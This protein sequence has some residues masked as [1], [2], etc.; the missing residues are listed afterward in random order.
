MQENKPTTPETPEEIETKRFLEE[1]RRRR[2]QS[3]PAPDPYAEVIA[4][5]KLK[6]KKPQSFL[7]RHHILTQHVQLNVLFCFTALV[8]AF[9]SGWMLKSQLSPTLKSTVSAEQ[10]QKYTETMQRHIS[11]PTAS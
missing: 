10:E 9:I 4:V 7:V 1:M 5:A 3:E 11:P 2:A 6:E 8:A